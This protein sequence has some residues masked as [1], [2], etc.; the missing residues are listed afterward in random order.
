MKKVYS[1]SLK[2]ILI[3]IV[4]SFI[5]LGLYFNRTYQVD[6][7]TKGGTIYKSIQV[8]PN[9]IIEKPNDPL[10]EGYIFT[11]WYKDNEE[12]EY[13]FSKEVTSSFVL[14]AKWKKIS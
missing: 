7:N 2:T 13:D 1:Y 4:F 12:T 14:N 8:K 11:G 5:L 9:S 3:A 6:F 10:M